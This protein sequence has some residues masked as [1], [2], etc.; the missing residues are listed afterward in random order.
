MASP[1]RAARS[2][3]VAG[4][5]WPGMRRGARALLRVEGEDAGDGEPGGGDE[6]EQLVDVGL[7]LAGEAD[8]EG[9]AHGDARA[10]RGARAPSRREVGVAVAGAPHAP[11]DGPRGVLQR[12]VDVRHRVRGERLEEASS[13]PSGCR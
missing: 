3:G 4:G 7:G 8:D 10:G 2:A 1:R 5:T 9:R 11:Q 12:E 13:T 6:V